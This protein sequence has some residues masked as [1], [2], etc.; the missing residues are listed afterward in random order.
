M[1]IRLDYTASYY[2]TFRRRL[3]FKCPF[4]IKQFDDQ[5]WIDILQVP[6][7][8]AGELNDCICNLYIMPL[9]LAM[10]NYPIDPIIIIKANNSLVRRS[11]CVLSN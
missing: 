7:E 1:A 3:L 6:E 10:E 9:M 11:D 5:Q 2:L 8:S 4:G